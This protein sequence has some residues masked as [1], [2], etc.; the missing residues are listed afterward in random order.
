[1]SNLQCRGTERSLLE[2]YQQACNVLSC[3]HRSDVGVVCESEIFKFSTFWNITS[4][5]APCINGSIRLG[6]GAVLRGRVEV[7]YNGSWVT[8]CSHSW[9]AKEATVICSHLGYSHYGRVKIIVT[10]AFILNK[11]TQVLLQYLMLLSTMSG[12]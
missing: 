9:T 1:M 10:N 11:F 12:Q 2:C 8:I 6:D 3:T 7:C 4:F 5:L